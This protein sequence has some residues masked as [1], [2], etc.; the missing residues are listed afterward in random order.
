MREGEKGNKWWF[1]KGK[2]K[3]YISGST[4]SR[5]HHFALR[6]LSLNWYLNFNFEVEEKRSG[7]E[8]RLADIENVP[9]TISMIDNIL[10]FR[11]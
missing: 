2:L 1:E 4:R 10:S 7:E 6:L 9:K 11:I 8:I 5:L 3:G